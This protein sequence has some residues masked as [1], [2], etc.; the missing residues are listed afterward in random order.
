[1]DGR[2]REKGQGEADS[3]LS[4]EPWPWTQTQDPEMMTQAEG[5][6]LT[7]WAIQALQ[8]TASCYHLGPSIMAPS[9]K[10]TQ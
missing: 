8:I 10:G 4:W 3:T 1:M 7:N 6:P 9:Q 5:K 2:G